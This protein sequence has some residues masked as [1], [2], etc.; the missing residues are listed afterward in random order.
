MA[1]TSGLKRKEPE[2]EIKPSFCCVKCHQVLLDPITLPC[3]HSLDKVCLEQ[4][5]AAAK[6]AG[7]GGAKPCCPKPKCNAKIPTPLPKKVNDDMQKMVEIVYSKQVGAHEAY[8]RP[9]PIWLDPTADSTSRVSSGLTNRHRLLPGGRTAHLAPQQLIC[10]LERHRV[11]LNGAG[12]E[13]LV[14]LRHR[15]ELCE[16]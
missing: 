2:P 1:S 11:E 6:A 13:S 8:P 4:I 3:M 16:V 14:G 9:W 7:R 12:G 5:A 10:R 15:L